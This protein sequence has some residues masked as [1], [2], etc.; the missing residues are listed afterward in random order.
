M[1]AVLEVAIE[2]ESIAADAVA[3]VTFGTELTVTGVVIT[4]A[5]AAAVAGDVAAVESDAHLR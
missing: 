4:E 5:Y 1:G 2:T 3:E